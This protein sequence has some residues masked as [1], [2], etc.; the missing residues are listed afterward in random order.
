MA[1]HRYGANFFLYKLGYWL[2]VGII[3]VDVLAE[4]INTTHVLAAGASLLYGLVLD[5]FSSIFLFVFSLHPSWRSE[6]VRPSPKVAASTSDI[7]LEER[8]AKA[9][10][11]DM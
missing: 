5:F 8:E 1:T 6:H 3:P 11:R 9:M 2:T 7:V 10:P 4:K